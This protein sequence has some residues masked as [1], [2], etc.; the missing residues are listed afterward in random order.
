MLVEWVDGKLLPV[1]PP[2][3]ALHDPV[4]PKPAWGG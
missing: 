4:S 3:V 1:Y 2:A